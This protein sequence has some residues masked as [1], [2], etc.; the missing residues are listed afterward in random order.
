MKRH[1]EPNC[2]SDGRKAPNCPGRTLPLPLRTCCATSAAAA[3]DGPDPD[4]AGVTPLLAVGPPPA[5]PAA[6]PALRSPGPELAPVASVSGRPIASGGAG[7]PAM[8]TGE[9]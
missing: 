1:N 3:H 6:R 7:G 9:A 4:P 8:A 2:N 5:P